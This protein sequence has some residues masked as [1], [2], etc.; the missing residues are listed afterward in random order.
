M[1]SSA[2]YSA[3]LP[4]EHSG[5][6]FFLFGKKWNEPNLFRGEIPYQLLSWFTKWP[7]CP[8]NWPL[9][10]GVVARRF[11]SGCCLAVL[12]WQ[13]RSSCLYLPSQTKADPSTAVTT[14]NCLFSMRNRSQVN[15]SRDD[16]RFLLRMLIHLFFF[17]M[18]PGWRVALCFHSM[19]RSIDRI[20]CDRSKP[21]EDARAAWGPSMHFRCPLRIARSTT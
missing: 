9:S 3:K 21:S 8:W 6:R 13:L 4:K 16:V 5:E 12:L 11:T 18:L 17:N 10:C 20:V 15:D 7:A 2:Q 14:R 19:R 1:F